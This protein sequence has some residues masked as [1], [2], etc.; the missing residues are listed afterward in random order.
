MPTPRSTTMVHSRLPGTAHARGHFGFTNGHAA[1]G[2][3]VVCSAR[4][5][6]FS[7]TE[8]KE[9]STSWL[10]N[11]V[12]DPQSDPQPGSRSSVELQDLFTSNLRKGVTPLATAPNHS[13]T[14]STTAS[15]K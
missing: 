10:P 3:A 8:M 4:E 2:E 9:H 13:S 7:I 6:Q 11:P 15:H 5:C 1:M 12:A 14:P